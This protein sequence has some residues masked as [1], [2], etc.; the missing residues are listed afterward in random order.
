ME[1]QKKKKFR[2]KPDDRFTQ[3]GGGK[4]INK[5]KQKTPKRCSSDSTAHLWSFWIFFFNINLH[6]SGHKEIYESSHE[7]FKSPEILYLSPVRLPDFVGA[8]KSRGPSS[9]PCV[10][11][12]LL[13]ICVLT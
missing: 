11:F 5:T 10:S 2:Y 6:H 4:K 13:Y 12:S 9:R 1:K 8:P 3:S 7:N